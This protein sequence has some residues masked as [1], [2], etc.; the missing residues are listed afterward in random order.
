MNSNLK[1]IKIKIKPFTGYLHLLRKRLV[2]YHSYSKWRRNKIA[3]TNSSNLLRFLQVRMQMMS[4][5]MI[6]TVR[7]EGLE[8]F[9]ADRVF[10]TRSWPKKNVKLL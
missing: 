1:K 5:S 6:C 7:Q 9:G 10:Q 4:D 3:R 2:P 8:R